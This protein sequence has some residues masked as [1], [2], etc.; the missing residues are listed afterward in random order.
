[1]T[2]SDFRLARSTLGMTQHELA[3]ALGMGLWGWQSISKWENGSKPVPSD[4]E[5]ALMMLLE[6]HEVTP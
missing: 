5:T 3:S 2:P 1:M 4:K 6:L